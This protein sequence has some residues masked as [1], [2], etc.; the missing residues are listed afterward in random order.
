[1]T[2]Y[3][4]VENLSQASLMSVKKWRDAQRGVDRVIVL[5]VMRK[6]T[7]NPTFSSV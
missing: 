6:L 7:Q 3:L 5:W 4:E 2:A 1:M